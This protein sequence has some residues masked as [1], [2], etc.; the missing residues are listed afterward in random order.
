[1][2]EKEKNR[3]EAREGE[4]STGRTKFTYYDM[5]LFFIL[6]PLG[7]YWYINIAEPNFSCG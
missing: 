6:L 4:D 1:M 5:C 2:A 3:L 7:Y